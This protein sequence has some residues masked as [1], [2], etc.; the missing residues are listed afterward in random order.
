MND[1]IGGWGDVNDLIG[2]WDDVNDLIGGWGWREW[3]RYIQWW[4]VICFVDECL[5]TIRAAIA[6]FHLSCS[7]YYYPFLNLLSPP[8]PPHP[9][10]VTH[11]FHPAHDHRSFLQRQ[12]LGHCTPHHSMGGQ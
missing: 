7:I 3:A 2:G 11:L 5:R 4:G 10:H 12:A 9:A 6:I 1:L 8:Q